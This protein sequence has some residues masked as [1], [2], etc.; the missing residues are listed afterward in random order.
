M[1]IEVHW[2]QRQVKVTSTCL[3]SY[4]LAV[5]CGQP[6]VVV[7]PWG[8][9]GRLIFSEHL[10]LMFC[11]LQEGANCQLISPLPGVHEGLLI[12]WEF[13]FEAQAP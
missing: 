7:P 12:I 11:T 3:L 13:L 8:S 9:I 1:E 10:C 2:W 5:L 4:T 6:K